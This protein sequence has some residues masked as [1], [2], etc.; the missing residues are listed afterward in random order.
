MHPHTDTGRPPLHTHSVPP[1]SEV[2]LPAVHLPLHPRASS[3]TLSLS[4]PPVTQ[5]CN[6]PDISAAIPPEMGYSLPFH[7]ISV[8]DLPGFHL[9]FLLQNILQISETF[10]LSVHNAP[11]AVLSPHLL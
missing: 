9:I 3:S 7:I 6:P 4:V 1:V 10:R 8:S 11:Q 5:S 2:L